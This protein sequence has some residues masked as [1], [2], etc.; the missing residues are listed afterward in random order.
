[1][2]LPR[3]IICVVLFVPFMYGIVWLLRFSIDN[4]G[5]LGFGVMWLGILSFMLVTGRWIG[6]DFS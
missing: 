2:T 3:A 4:Y 5:Y 1:M 6:A